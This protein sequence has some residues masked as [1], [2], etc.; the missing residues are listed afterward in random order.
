MSD[1]G[2][3][4]LDARSVARVL[5][6]IGT[7]L[8]LNGESGFKARAYTR[9]ARELES[10]NVDLAALARANKLTELSGI[11]SGIAAVIRELVLT[12]QSKAYEEL[13]EKTPLALYDLRRV[14]G[15]GLKRIHQ[16]H[17]QL[18]IEDLEALERAAKEGRI[19]E[20]SGFGE[21]TERKILE[22]IEF[23][24]EARQLRRIPDATAVAERLC[25]T[26]AAH[27]TVER[28]EIAGA[29]RRRAEVVDEVRLL[30]A[31][32][33][34]P[35]LIE[36]LRA[37]PGGERTEGEGEPDLIEMRLS[38]GMHVCIRCIELPQFGAAWIWET[39]NDAHVAELVARAEARGLT[40]GREGISGAEGGSE[41]A[42]YEALGLRW[43]PPE[44]REGRGEI[45]VAAEHDLPPLVEEADLRG[46]FHCH[47]TASDGKATL[48]EMAEGARAMG[49][50]YLG[51]ADHSQS[52]AYAGGL[53]VAA[54]RT[55][56][57]EVAELNDAAGNGF[58]VFAGTEADILPNGDLDYPPEVLA[59]FD[60]VVGSV[61]SGFRMSEREMTQRMVR[62]LRNPWI[63]IL[64]HATGRLLL[65]REGYRFDMEK[66][67]RAA[68]DNE[69]VIEINA[70]PNRLDLD[71]RHVRR[72]AA[73]G[74]L[75]AINP[76]AHSVAALR[77][78]RYGIYMARKAGLTAEQVINTWSL[79][80]ITEYLA[81]RKQSRQEGANR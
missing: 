20:L 40:F 80:E 63:T 52:A 44:L 41:A 74:I 26:L 57:K 78:V 47:T 6:E 58:R 59:T 16:L 72:A 46:T 71:W 33:D 38:D 4:P 32:H 27:G 43:I 77:N 56:Q 49:W 8:E 50:E 14:P 18:G 81:K 60:Y 68:A 65:R 12:G 36:S 23:A 79:D 17:E 29:L 76:D 48:E 69:V 30:I 39:G 10:A 34:L 42:V 66:V 25:E 73:M 22:G 62:A 21:A 75:I 28:A 9:A 61:H 55:Q 54:V 2:D 31:A 7:L 1:V 19:A 15:L 5:A 64:G 3:Q 35:A 37:M 13:R 67:L 11:G 70:N 45:G 24:R 53:T 51:I